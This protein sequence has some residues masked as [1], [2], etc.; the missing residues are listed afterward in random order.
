M[1]Q[2]HVC[3]ILVISVNKTPVFVVSQFVNLTNKRRFVYTQL[4]KSR[5]FSD[6]SNTTILNGKELLFW[7]TKTDRNGAVQCTN[8]YLKRQPIKSYEKRNA[9]L[10][11]VNWHVWGLGNH[12]FSHFYEEQQS[13]KISLVITNYINN[14]SNT[15][16][17]Y[18]ASL[19][20]SSVFLSKRE[21]LDPQML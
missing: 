1:N 8:Y 10:L 21:D 12:M 4:T 20:N 5:V 16:L 2:Y 18:N 3:L 13:T 15:R 9:S 7:T 11:M 6:N 19:L 17:V 14:S